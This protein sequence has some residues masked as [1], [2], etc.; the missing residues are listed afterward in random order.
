MTEQMIA[1]AVALAG[2]EAA[3]PAAPLLAELTEREILNYTNRAEL[4]PELELIAAQILADVFKNGSG[5]GG[6]AV[7]SIKEGD[8]S[9]TF[10]ALPAGASA[11]E[12]YKPQLMGFR[13]LT[14]R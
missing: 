13:K 4:P 1:N 5:A 2:L 12:R 8:T 6:S 11:W 14:R 7:Q 3:P 9:I 10:A